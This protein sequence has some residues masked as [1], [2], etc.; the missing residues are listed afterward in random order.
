MSPNSYHSFIHSFNKYVPGID[1][2]SGCKTEELFPVFKEY[3]EKRP[4]SPT[5]D[6]VCRNPSVLDYFILVHEMSLITHK[7]TN[8]LYLARYLA[9]WNKF[10]PE[11]ASIK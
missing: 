9:L 10:V 8:Y 1:L 7:W 5:A 6:G 2:D 4:D 11:N 3:R